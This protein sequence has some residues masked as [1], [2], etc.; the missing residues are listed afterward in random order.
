[1]NLIWSAEAR[2]ELRAIRRFI[3]R[4]SEH[5]A[6]RIITRLIECAESILLSPRRGHVVH[7]YPEAPLREIHEPPYRIIYELSEN[8]VR[9]VTIVHFKQRLKLPSA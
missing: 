9:I 1:M 5:Y 7:E 2:Q 6:A 3:A 8:A 4:D